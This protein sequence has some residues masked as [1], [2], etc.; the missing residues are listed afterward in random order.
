MAMPRTF[1]QMAEDT[2]RLIK[3]GGV[4]KANVHEEQVLGNNQ[5]LNSEQQFDIL[6][7]IF[8]LESACSTMCEY[9]NALHNMF[10]LLRPGGIIIIGSV[11]E[12]K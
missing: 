6:I 1:E 5:N 8:C 9:K 7:S 2:R 4:L 11:I 10:K 3:N 12:G